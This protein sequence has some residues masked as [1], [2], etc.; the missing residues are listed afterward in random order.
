MRIIENKRGE[1]NGVMKESHLIVVESAIPANS[2][3]GVKEEKTNSEH[4][5]VSHLGN[6][7]SSLVYSIQITHKTFS[8]PPKGAFINFQLT[9]KAIQIINLNFQENDWLGLYFGK[10][11]PE[12]DQRALGQ[13]EE[14][15]YFE[16]PFHV[17]YTTVHG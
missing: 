9:L 15:G 13:K 14:N 10:C 4:N 17:R 7:L 3:F 8:K 1:E 2:T 16:Y 6:R 12:I 11:Y 5:M